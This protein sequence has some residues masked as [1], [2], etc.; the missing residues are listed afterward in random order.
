M[1]KYLLSG[2]FAAVLMLGA[3]GGGE[4]AEESTEETAD[5]ETTEETTEEADTVAEST[6]ESTEEETTEEETA[7]STEATEQAEAEGKEEIAS[8]VDADTDVVEEVSEDNAAMH[9]V[10]DETLELDTVNLTVEEAIITNVET[11]Q[12]DAAM[13]TSRDVEAGQVVEVLAIKYTLENTTDDPRTFFIDQSEIVTS[14]GQQLSPEMLLSE[15]LTPNMQ[16]AVSSTGTVL[17]LL[18]DGT[19]ESVEW[20]DVLLPMVA[21]RDFNMY[22]DEQ[23]YRIEF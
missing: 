13:I 23:K 3:C 21:D 2:G 14:T 16:G 11:N 4:S 12:M 20:V 10:V 1:K 17:Y 6:E 5:E 9:T 22:T 15:G 19:G 8:E 7:G 18:D